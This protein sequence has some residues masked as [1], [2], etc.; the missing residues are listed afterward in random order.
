MK[1]NMMDLRKC[2]FIMWWNLKI[3]PTNGGDNCI[4]MGMDGSNPFGGWQPNVEDL[5]AT[6]WIVTE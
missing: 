6:D 1:I 4:M 5:V 3:K 2:T